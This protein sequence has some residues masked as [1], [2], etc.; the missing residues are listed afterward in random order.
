M[1]RLSRFKPLYGCC[2]LWISVEEFLSRGFLK[3]ETGGLFAKMECLNLFGT[4]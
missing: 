4:S 1:K 3:L 2:D